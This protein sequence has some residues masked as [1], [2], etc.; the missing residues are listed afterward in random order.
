M[1]S[2]ICSTAGCPTIH[3]GPGSRCPTHTKDARRRHWTNTKAYNTKAHRVTFR[4]GVLDRDPI[5]TLCHVRASVVADHYPHA[6]QDLIDLA[7]DPNDPQ[8]GRG[9]CIQCD[10]QQTAQRQPGG[11]HKATQAD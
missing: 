1:P 4:L 5:C 11:W 3:E 10:K 2:R 6:R 9:L 8:Y 7:L